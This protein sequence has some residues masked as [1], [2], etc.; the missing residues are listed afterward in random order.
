MELVY[1]NEKALKVI[2]IV[3]SALVWA[4][5]LYATR[6]LVLM[7]LLLFA[8]FYLFAQS[9]LIA[10]IK[11][12]GV[13]VSDDQYSDIHERFKKCCL[14]LEI[15][16]EPDCYVLRTNTFNAFA[17][18]FLGRNF[19]VLFADVLDALKDDPAALNFY[20]G[21]ELGHLRRKHLLWKP[22]LLPSSFLPLIGAGYHRACEYTCD[23]HG[24]ACSETP[25]AA[26][27]GLLAIATANSRVGST[28]ATAFARQV[29]ESA[30]FWM[31]FHELIADYPWLS[32]RVNAVSALSASKAPTHPRRN[33]FAW[34][35]A[36]FVPRLGVAAS[37]GAG[38]LVPVAIIGII[39]AI[40]IPAYQDYTIR[41]QITVGLNVATRYQAGVAQAVE[42]RGGEVAGV[43]NRLIGLPE[44]GNTRFV[45]SIK[46]V[47]GAIVITYGAGANPAITNQTV[48]LVPGRKAGHG[49]VWV[50][51]HADSPSGVQVAVD[52]YQRY[53]SVPDKWLPTAC[54]AGGTH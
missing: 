4:V 40:A 13:R 26:Q 31:S 8:L 36:L 46:V 27:Q 6:G 5:V 25:A 42:D 7:Y 18:R 17:T 20:I 38:L 49:L 22:F 23:R 41:S 48:V 33:P 44:S 10:H 47:N 15:D 21:H 3:I 19:V 52:N 16:S 43:D 24:L 35:L 11:G 29:E 51:G 9:G 54:R 28:S 32:K 53:T 50:C 30:G 14:R 45:Q 37:A 34:V 1:A 2:S 39:A 12:T